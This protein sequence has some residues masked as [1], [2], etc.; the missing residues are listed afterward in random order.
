MFIPGA[1]HSA[2]WA[3]GQSSAVD[4]M[5][6][7]AEEAASDPSPGSAPACC[8]NDVFGTY[9][10][11]GLLAYCDVDMR[12]EKRKLLFALPLLSSISGSNSFAVVLLRCRVWA[13]GPDRA[14]GRRACLLPTEHDAGDRAEERGHRKSTRLRWSTAA[15]ATRIIASATYVLHGRYGRCTAWARVATVLALH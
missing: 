8:V 1:T 7:S 5:P 2:A 15:A 3:A 9:G 10:Q 11:N 12:Y 6:W 14:P 4:S 13:A